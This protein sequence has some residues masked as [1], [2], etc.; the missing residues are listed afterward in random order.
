MKISV[1]E[2]SSLLDCW[3]E[4]GELEG[5]PKRLQRA[6]EV[7]FG[8]FHHPTAPVIASALLNPSKFRLPETI[9][10]DENGVQGTRKNQNIILDS[11]VKPLPRHII[12]INWGEFLCQ[13]MVAKVLPFQRSRIEYGLCYRLGR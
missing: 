6:C 1:D 2:L 4:D 3:S 12:T 9:V 8:S 13:H 11:V 10:D 5:L 7:E